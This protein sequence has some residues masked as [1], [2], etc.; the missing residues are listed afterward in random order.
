MKW[1]GGDDN[2]PCWREAEVEFN[3]SFDLRLIDA[4]PEFYHASIPEDLA[5]E[6]LTIEQVQLLETTRDGLVAD[7]ITKAIVA[8]EVPE[9][10]SIDLQPE[11]EGFS[12]PW[13]TGTR[14]VD[15]RHIA[16]LLYTA[17][18]TFDP[19][20]EPTYV[21]ED[22]VLVFD[23]TNVLE[24]V[25]DQGQRHSVGKAIRIV[26]PPVILM[27]GTFD[28]PMEAWQTKFD[29]PAAG[30]ET[31]QRALEKE[32]Y[33]VFAVD[34][35]ST[36]GDSDSGPSSF[37]DNRLVL[38][39]NPG[40]IENA[41]EY[42][43]DE[44]KIA[45]TQVDVVGHSMGGVLPRV[46]ASIQYNGDYY[47]P[48]NFWEGDINRL[49]TIAGS[50]FGSHLGELQIEMEDATLID[51]GPLDWILTQVQNF[52]LKWY[53]GTAASDAVRDQRPAPGGTALALI[54]NTDIPSHAI[55]GSVPVGALKDPV[56]DPMQEYYDLYWYT[57]LL[58]YYNS[59]IRENYLQYKLDL[60]EL[61]FGASTTWDG[62]P[63]DD[64]LRLASDA[65]LFK[66][67]IDDAIKQG[68]KILEA[69]DGEF[70]LPSNIEIFSYA[71][72]ET[73][74]SDINVV[75]PL[76]FLFEA[77]ADPVGVVTDFFFDAVMPSEEEI[78]TALES[79]HDK[80]IEGMRSLIFN[81][82]ANDG[83]VRVE[84]QRGDI[85]E[86]YS[87]H[88]D[89]V[90]HGFA[91][92]YTEI[93]D[94]V[95][96]LLG[97]GM[98]GFNMDGFP[99]PDHVQPL[100]LPPSGLD[101]Y[102][103]PLS[104]APAV[105]QSGMV[106]EH[107]RAFASVADQRNTIII[108]RPVNPDAT[109]LIAKGAA[110]KVMD[111]KPKSSNWGPQ[112]GY[113]PVDQRYSKLWKLFEGNE[114]ENKIDTYNE[115]VAENLNAMLVA[116]RPLQIEICNA[117]YNVHID[118]NQLMDDCAEN[119]VVLVPV[120]DPS[121]VCYWG[122]NICSASGYV[123]FS[124]NDLITDCVE[125]GVGHDLIPF[126][127]IATVPADG[128]PSNFITADYD[129][130]MI[131]F[132]AGE[133]LEYTQPE[134]VDFQPGT[135]QIKPDQQDLIEVLNAAVNHSGGD[136]VHHGPENQFS[137]SPYID[138]PLTVFAP[139]DIPGPSSGKVLSL[140]MGDRGFRDIEL[141]QYVNRMRAEGYDLYDNPVA[142]GWHWEWNETFKG[143]LLEDSPLLG[144]YVE[145][146][147]K[148]SCDKQG[149]EENTI[150]ISTEP[151]A[152]TSTQRPQGWLTGSRSPQ[153]GFS[154][155]VH[156]NLVAGNSFSMVIEA[157]SETTVQLVIS[158]VMG[159]Q[160]QYVTVEVA[161]GTN[162]VDLSLR[163]DLDSGVYTIT[164]VPMGVS[165]R[166]IKL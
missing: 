85:G 73:G 139:D 20:E 78:R 153:G 8:L 13:G 46:Y 49:I 103:P 166:F 83:V 27:H 58:L 136:V 157:A 42:Y 99:A 120:H 25:T 147:P 40:G 87:T 15:D 98:S 80:S 116:T 53:T 127:V 165:Q 92:R 5:I 113:L 57:E 137:L 11:S 39:S 62:E 110:T 41:L 152:S 93:Q 95:I 149:N 77:S 68:G 81:N 164:V 63:I 132:Y 86:A 129:L 12:T 55:T 123:D 44:L 56:R 144:D 9:E 160:R 88:F 52:I 59:A 89:H 82:D 76:L 60:A 30:T 4:N 125:S 74:M 156:P 16:Y 6:N 70:E 146:M 101:L 19:G 162:E 79:T 61:G 10:G 33:C 122:D 34:Y 47:N 26:R 158:D 7:G 163:G 1:N 105:C 43:R 67:M 106:P 109:P 24:Y 31:F 138:Y 69:I 159:M 23:L 118:K 3:C 90:F 107:A 94:R 91:P 115:K 135:G 37:M 84:S 54:G 124:Y 142:P 128:E 112:K 50:H 38:R 66:D 141:K 134:E 108:V 133:D 100:Y 104:G 71:L 48:R 17:P 140:S 51:L 29:D 131:G 28:N 143:F 2:S 126:E 130:L 64:A 161:A 151:T 145:Q 75:D 102:R 117:T 35:Q 14:E 65:I 155:T 97:G 21:Y 111:V 18:E 114:R 148:R 72:N 150:C 154:L 45:T 119:D 32:K 36:N 22:T 121:M 96:T